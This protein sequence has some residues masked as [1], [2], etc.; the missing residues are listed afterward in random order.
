MTLPERLD[1]LARMTGLPALF[2]RLASGRQRRHLRWLPIILLLLVSG[3]MASILVRPD[4]YW[5][6]YWALMLGNLIGGC[7]PIFGPI[8]PWGERKG[9]D[10][11]ERQ[12]RRDAYF[13][14]F[15]TISVVAVVGLF[16]LIGLTLLNR[17][18]IGTL[19]FDLAMF[20]FFLILLWEIIPTLHAS[21]ASRP[22]EDE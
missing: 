3:G 7:L 16:L 22:I 11:R 4:I 8:K 6:G 20:T 17:W 12:V 1:D 10:E 15:A 9:A 21:W 5:P 18:K 19:I 2:A 14:A 13:A